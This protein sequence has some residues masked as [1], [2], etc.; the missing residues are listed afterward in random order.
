M[1]LPES[2]EEAVLLSMAVAVTDD[3]WSI[4]S[5]VPVPDDEAQAPAV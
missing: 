1:A 5:L 2:E 3:D 4:S